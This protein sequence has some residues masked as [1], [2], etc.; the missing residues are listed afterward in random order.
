MV[1]RDTAGAGHEG[2]GADAGR[3]GFRRRGRAFTVVAVLIGG[4]VF[5]TSFAFLAAGFRQRQDPPS[6]LRSTGISAGVPAFLAD[7]MGLSPV[8]AREAPRFT[9]TDQA[10][11]RLS[12]ASLRG[13]AVVLEFTDPHCTGICPIIAREFIDA[14]HDLGTRVPKVVLIAVSVNPYR[15]SAADVAAYSREH[16]LAVIA[17]WHFPTGTLPALR[18]VWRGYG[19]AVYATGPDADV[20]RTTAPYVIDPAGRLRF[21]AFP[22]VNHTAGGSPCLPAGQPGERGRSIGLV[23]GLLAG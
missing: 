19:A 15:R 20:I 5:A 23:A 11:R 8:P 9:L 7:L 18:A 22:T 10:G 4:L 14:N 3:R 17:S 1:Q 13:R 16:Q 21:V 6:R 2:T 12:L